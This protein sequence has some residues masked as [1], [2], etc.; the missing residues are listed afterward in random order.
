MQA[1]MLAQG[2][3]NSAPFPNKTAQNFTVLKFTHAL[4]KTAVGVFLWFSLRLYAG[5]YSAEVKNVRAMPPLANK[6]FFF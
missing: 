3:R 4:T 6:Y 2:M 1:L 5:P